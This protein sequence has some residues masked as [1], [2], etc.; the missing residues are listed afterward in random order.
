MTGMEQ[1]QPSNEQRQ[2]SAKHQVRREKSLMY[3][4][5]MTSN[6]DKL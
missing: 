3:H 2:P 5:N 1:H 6:K 4:H